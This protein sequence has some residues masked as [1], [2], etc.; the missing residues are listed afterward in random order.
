VDTTAIARASSIPR[1]AKLAFALSAA[2]GVAAAVAVPLLI[3]SLPPESR[4]LPLRLAAFC[5]VLAVQMT[6]VYGLV[7]LAGLRLARRG[8]LQPAPF[9]SGWTAEMG[10]RHATAFAAGIGLGLMLV[11]SVATIRW[12][13][14]ATLPP[15][16]HPPSPAAALAAST[17]G[18]LGEEILFRLF[19]LSL[20]LC[21]LPCRPWKVGLAVALSSLLFAAAHSPA[22][23][24]LYGGLASVPAVSWVWL[25]SLNGLLGAAFGIVFLRG[26][27]LAAVLAHFGTDLVWHVASQLAN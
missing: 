10:R 5:A 23:V 9:L 6:V 14:P 17:V 27:I 26:G 18:S 11:I 21:L 12:I 20:L 16:L 7:A 13:A 19:L 4:K 3:D 1:D 15:A 24:F 25:I 8:G 22:F 2:L